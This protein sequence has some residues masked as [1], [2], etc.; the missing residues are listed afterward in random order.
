MK[1]NFLWAIACVGVACMLVS[2]QSVKASSKITQLEEGKEYSYDLNLDGKEET[3][4]YSMKK[5]IYKVFINGK[6]VKK[7]KLNE[8]SYSPNLQITDIDTSDSRLDLCTYAYCWSEDI[9]YSAIYEY[10]GT[11]LNQILNIKDKF[12][13]DSI[14][15]RPGYIGDTD[16]KGNFNVIMDRAIHVDNLTGN[17]FDKIPYKLANGKVKRV[18][19]NY[20]QFDGYSSYNH[21]KN[22]AYFIASQTLSFLKKPALNAK[23]SFKLSKKGKVYPVKMYVSNKGVAYVQFK[24]KKG[25]TGWL[26]CSDFSYDNTPFSNLAFAD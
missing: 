26:K 9:E 14:D 20:Y 13:N 24:T 25:K 6:V 15:L 7:I 8:E 21:D 12:I 19:T 11:T 1:N 4:S 23:T 18:K 5:G 2:S 22:G 17:H 3:L 16:G 10:D